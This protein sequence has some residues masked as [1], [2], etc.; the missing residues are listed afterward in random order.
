MPSRTGRRKCNPNDVESSSVDC[1]FCGINGIT[2]EF[3]LC[4]T[5]AESYLCERCVKDAQIVHYNNIMCHACLQKKADKKSDSSQKHLIAVQKRIKM[6][7][8]AQ[9]SIEE[10]KKRKFRKQLFYNVKFLSN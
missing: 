10:L 8:E 5:C 7:K 3:Y 4:N 9:V 6:L 1:A 2:T